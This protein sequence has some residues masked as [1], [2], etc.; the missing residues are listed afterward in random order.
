M[1]SALARTGIT[2]GVIGDARGRQRRRHRWT[3]A[4]AVAIAIATGGSF[5]AVGGAF[6]GGHAR[7]P[8]Q[9]AART[10]R[11]PAVAIRCRTPARFSWRIARLRGRVV[12]L[13][14]DCGGHR[15]VIRG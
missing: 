8:R 10:N 7:T 4:A 12:Y 15:V 1:D 11:G 2:F 3:L 6:N 9:L 5:A 14:A 13:I